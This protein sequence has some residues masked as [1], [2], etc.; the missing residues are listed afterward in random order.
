MKYVQLMQ[1]FKA[2]LPIWSVAPYNIISSHHTHYWSWG[3]FSVP[4]LELICVSK[5]DHW[6]SWIEICSL[7]IGDDIGVKT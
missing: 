6:G 4:G 3:Y 5:G 7:L 2:S 1:H